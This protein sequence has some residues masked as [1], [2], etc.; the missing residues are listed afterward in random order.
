[1]ERRYEGSHTLFL[2][3]RAQSMSLQICSN[4]FTIY[5]SMTEAISMNVLDW[6]NCLSKSWNLDYRLYKIIDIDVPS[7]AMFM[8]IDNVLMLYERFPRE[9]V[10]TAQLPCA[11]NIKIYC[12]FINKVLQITYTFHIFMFKISLI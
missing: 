7:A 5:N 11:S 1:M 9:E 2:E 10:A 4:F 12:C 6:V 3:S 8:N